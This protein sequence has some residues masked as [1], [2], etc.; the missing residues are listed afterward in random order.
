MPE[1]LCAICEYRLTS[2]QMDCCSIGCQNE[3]KERRRPS[4]IYAL[5]PRERQIF[6]LYL[7]GNPMKQIGILLQIDPRTVD[8]HKR[9][10]MRKLGARNSIDLVREG[11]KQGLI[12]L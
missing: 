11:L 4:G 7:E 9:N 3:L 12:A 2:K 1:R 10:L 6:A 5:S 8:T